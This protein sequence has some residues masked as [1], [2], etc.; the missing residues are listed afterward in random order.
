MTG[1]LFLNAS[2]S[3]RFRALK[4]LSQDNVNAFIQKF[5]FN[6]TKHVTVIYSSFNYE[7]I[8]KNASVSNKDG[9]GL[10]LE[11]TFKRIA[12]VSKVKVSIDSLILQ[13]GQKS[14]PLPNKQNRIK[15]Y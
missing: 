9:L 6:W 8:S 5:F 4:S 7:A 1:D 13:D 15:S 10:C 2:I 3:S 11:Q 14:K 12:L